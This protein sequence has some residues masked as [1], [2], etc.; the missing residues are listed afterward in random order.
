MKVGLLICDEVRAE[1]QSE[2]GDYPAMF[3]ALFSDYEFEHYQ[4]NKG[5]FPENVMDCEVYMATGSSRSTYEDLAWIQQTKAF[6]RA[7]YE[8]NRFFIGF[9]FGH[10][11][12]ADALG[13]KVEKAAT[14][15]CVGVHE[16]EI[17][18]R[19]HWMQPAKSEVNFLM[20]CQDQVMELPPNT[21]RLAGSKDCPNAILQVGERMLSIQAHPE[22]TKAYDQV[23]MESRAERIGIEKVTKGIASLEKSLDTQLFR[24]WVAAFLER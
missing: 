8:A 5:E 24:A 15:W 10:Q 3:Q 21:I 9:C 22:F 1:Y 7:I 19:K 14:G 11:L 20:M 16:F 17:I 18:H 23:L 13:G 12:L 6:I 2:F 4:V